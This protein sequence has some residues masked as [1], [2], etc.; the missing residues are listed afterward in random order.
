MSGEVPVLP[1]VVPLAVVVFALLV[2]H[3]QRRGLLSMPRAAVAL[4]LCVYAAGIVAN[5]IFPIFLD[6]PARSA[7]WSMFITGTPII[8]YEV[9]DALMNICVFVPVGVLVPLV[10]PRLSSV[11]VLLV[12]TVLSAVME[13]SQYATA[14][15]LNGG[16]VADVNDW[17]FNVVG[18]GLGYGLLV[19]LS[20]VP[21]IARP[22]ARFRWIPNRDREQCQTASVV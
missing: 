22:I 19:A 10:A 21:S 5:T 14:H 3:L 4:A 16:H 17:L 13:V 7:H 2:R 1:T 8:G 9:G 11:R 6:K 15:L 12:A 18:A 20:R